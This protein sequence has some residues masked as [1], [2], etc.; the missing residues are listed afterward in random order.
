MS[1]IVS[2]LSVYLLVCMVYQYFSSLTHGLMSGIF[3]QSYTLTVL[4]DSDIGYIYTPQSL[5]PKSLWLSEMFEVVRHRCQVA[6][7][8]V[9]VCRC[10]GAVVQRLLRRSPPPNPS[11]CNVTHLSFLPTFCF[12][13]QRSSLTLS[14]IIGCEEHRNAFCSV[15]WEFLKL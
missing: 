12:S 1:H 14:P 11:S 13:L 3:A 10:H 5:P 2:I 6:C 4:S 9:P 7:V 15:V 8:T